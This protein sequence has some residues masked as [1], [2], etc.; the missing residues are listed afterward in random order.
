MLYKQR[1]SGWGVG[2]WECQFSI[3][4]HGQSH[5][6]EHLEETAMGMLSADLSLCGG[7]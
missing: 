7:E 3:D 5:N 4:M 1:V 6:A 2:G